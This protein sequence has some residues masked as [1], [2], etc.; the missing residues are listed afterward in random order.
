M[1]IDLGEGKTLV[2]YYVWSDPGGMLPPGPASRFAGGA[3]K[4]TLIAMRG[5]ALEHQ[6]GTAYGSGFVKPDQSSLP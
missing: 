6:Q 2:E 3:V 4:D 5:L 1:L